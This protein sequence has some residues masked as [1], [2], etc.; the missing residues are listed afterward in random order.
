MVDTTFW[1]IENEEQ[2]NELAA[3]YTKYKNILYAI[4]HSNLHNEVDAEDAVQEVFSEIA[5]K[6][7]TFFGVPPE[8]RPAYLKS[9]VKKLSVNMFNAQNKIPKVSMDELTEKFETVSVTLEN[10][11]FDKIDYN[12]V[13]EFVNKL[14]KM[15]RNV[16]IFHCLYDLS[17]DETAL[18]LNIS[19]S[20]VHKHLFL[21][22][23][24]VRAFVDRRRNY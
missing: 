24:A 9:M 3:L 12:E 16:L 11:L 21:A 5:D 10:A 8:K 4:A 2:R 6:P 17:I 14:P 1:V 18:R 13:M 15:Q 20:G 7:E 19:I 22:R 23:K